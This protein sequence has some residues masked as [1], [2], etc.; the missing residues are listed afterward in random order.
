V[1]GDPGSAAHRHRNIGNVQDDFLNL[2]LRQRHTHGAHTFSTV[3]TGGFS[4]RA[5]SIGEFG[6]GVQV[7]II[8]FMILGAINLTREEVFICNVLKHRPPGNRNPTPVEAANCRE[9][10]DAQLA[11]VDPEYIVCWG[12]V[13]AGNLLG[14]KTPIGRLRGT[15]SRAGYAPLR[16]SAS[17]RRLAASISAWACMRPG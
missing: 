14:V 6:T 11:I 15:G 12:L 17:V 8:I 3:A 5:G 13:A 10:L 9:Y 7:I 4:P 2:T 1:A 16:R